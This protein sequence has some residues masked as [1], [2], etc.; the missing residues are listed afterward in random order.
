MSKSSRGS[1]RGSSKGSTPIRQIANMNLGTDSDLLPPTLRFWNKAISAKLIKD[2]FRISKTPGK[3]AAFPGSA[4]TPCK[5]AVNH[6]Q[7]SVNPTKIKDG[8]LFMYNITVV[9]PW[10]REYKRSDRPLYQQVIQKWKKEEPLLANEEFNWVYDGGKTLYSTKHLQ[11]TDK[12]TW[13]VKVRKRD[14]CGNPWSMIESILLMISKYVLVK[15]RETMEAEQEREF[16]IKDFG[17]VK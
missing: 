11:N 8:V 14:C 6:F 9:P 15:V 13:I 1:S 10:I 16:T 2:V 17:M 12:K 5:L 4:G 7:V 3:P